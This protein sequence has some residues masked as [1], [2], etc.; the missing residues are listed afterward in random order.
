MTGA[1][2]E[3]LLGKGVRLPAPEAVHVGDEVS[4]HTIDAGVTIHPGSRLEGSRLSIGPGCIIGGEGPATIVDCQLGAGVRLGG[5]FF[6]GSCFLDGV[7]IGNNA[8]VRP[9]C[10]FE[11]HSSLAHAVGVKQTIFMPWVTAGSLINFCDVLMAGGTGTK[12]H[13]E[14]GSSY[15]HFNFT[16]RQD[17][18]T[19]SLVGD[20]P[21]GVLLNQAPIFLGGQGGLV[22]PCRIAFGTVLAAGQ[23]FRE[24]IL[25]P[26]RLI[27]GT[28]QAASAD[29]PFNPAHCGSAERVFANNLVYIGNLLALDRWYRLVRA[30]YMNASRHQAACHRGARET[31]TL[32]LRERLQRLDEYVDKLLRT[33]QTESTSDFRLRLSGRWTVLRS[34]LEEL[35]QTRHDARVPPAVAAIIEH[36]PRR[37]YLAEIQRITTSDAATILSWLSE[38]VKGVAGLGAELSSPAVE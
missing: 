19:S 24:D 1:V 35:A 34:H 27:A 8:H 5:G 16:P 9:G 29:K 22:G 18:A 10:L 7:R 3:Q 11:E 23:V 20:V 14:I 33:S 37:D 26:G 6:S 25:E 32:I 21:H 13:S 2:L 30:Q 4:P 12:F 28:R 17:K 36:L 15:V 31:I 38:V